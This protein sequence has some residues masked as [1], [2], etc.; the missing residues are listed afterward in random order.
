MGVRELLKLL[1]NKVKPQVLY[2]DDV[3]EDFRAKWASVS[4]PETSSPSSPSSKPRTQSPVLLVDFQAFSF[5]ILES[6]EDE[7]SSWDFHTVST[8]ARNFVE[9][10]RHHGV[11][12]ILVD[13]GA[14]GSSGK[15]EMEAKLEEW[16]KRADERVRDVRKLKEYLE[17]TGIERPKKL[18][19]GGLFT[20]ALRHGLQDAEL[21]LSEGEADPILAAELMSPRTIGILGNDTDFVLMKHGKFIHLDHLEETR[22]LPKTLPTQKCQLKL[23][24]W[25]RQQL[26]MTLEVSEQVLPMAAALCGNDHSRRLIEQCRSRGLKGK[27][28]DVLSDQFEDLAKL[29]QKALD[30]GKQ[31]EEAALDLLASTLYDFVEYGWATKVILAVQCFYAPQRETYVPETDP[32]MEKVR[33]DVRSGKLPK[34]CWPLAAHGIYF[35]QRVLDDPGLGSCATGMLM[36]LKTPAFS[37]LAPLSSGAKTSAI[38]KVQVRILGSA[39]ETKSFEDT[40]KLWNNEG[41]VYMYLKKT[42]EER[43]QWLHR[44]ISGDSVAYHK[45]EFGDKDKAMTVRELHLFSLRFTLRFAKKLKLTEMEFESLMFIAYYLSTDGVEMD[46]VGMVSTPSFRCL[47]LGAW[48]Q[49]VIV[50]ILD[51]CKLLHVSPTPLAEQLFD[52]TRFLQ[53]FQYFSQNA[54]QRRPRYRGKMGLRSRDGG[55]RKSPGDA[56]LERLSSSDDYWAWREEVTSGLN[57]E[58]LRSSSSAFD[59]IEGTSNVPN[60]PIGSISVGLPIEEHK[61]TLCNALLENRV[62]CVRGETGSGKSTQ[63]PQYILELFPEARI[64]VTQP[65]RM[66]AVNLAKRVAK[67]RHEELGECVGYRIGGDSVV[68]K[69]LNFQTTGWLLRALV[70]DTSRLEKLTHVVFDEIHE[71]SADADFLSLVVR[72]LLHRCPEVKLVIMSATLQADLFSVYFQEL[73][74]AQAKVPLVEVGGKCFQVRKVFLD[75]IKDFCKEGLSSQGQSLLWRL[76]QKFQDQKMEKK[77]SQAL[78]D[79]AS[80]CTPLIID[81]L[82]F[83]AKSACTI[84]VFLPGLQEITD[85]YDECQRILHAADGAVPENDDADDAVNGENPAEAE[86]QRR[87]FTMKFKVFAMHSQIPMEDQMAVFQTPAEDVCHFVLASNVAESSLTLPNVSAVLDLGM[88]K[89]QVYDH[90]MK[91]TYL[92]LK[93]TSKASAHQRSG[94]AGRTM[95]GT[96]VRLYPRSFYETHLPDFD[97]PETAVLPLPRLY[98]QAKQLAKDLAQMA[99]N[100]DDEAVVSTACSVLTGLVDPPDLSIVEASRCELAE[101]YALEAPEETAEMTAIGRACLSLPFDLSLSR[102]VWFGIHWGCAVDGVILACSL[103]VQDPFSSPSSFTFPDL[104]DLGPRLYRSN[105]SRQHF[106]KGMK[107]Q[108]LALLELFKEFYQTFPLDPA[109]DGR[110]GWLKHAHTMVRDYDYAV[111]PR[112]LTE[113]VAQVDEVAQRLVS[114]VKKDSEAQRRLARLLA[115]LGRRTLDNLGTEFTD[116]ANYQ[117]PTPWDEGEKL[118]VHDFVESKEAKTKRIMNRKKMIGKVFEEDTDMLRALL[119]ASFSDRLLTS[120][121]KQSETRKNAKLFRAMTEMAGHERADL[122]RCILLKIPEKLP[123]EISVSHLVKLMLANPLRNFKHLGIIDEHECIQ[124]QGAGEENQE[125]SSLMPSDLDADLHVLNQLTR[126]KPLGQCQLDLKKLQLVREGN[127]TGTVVPLTVVKPVHPCQLTWE[128]HASVEE[129]QKGRQSKMRRGIPE[130]HSAIGFVC[131]LPESPP[132]SEGENQRDERAIFAEQLSQMEQVWYGCCSQVQYTQGIICF[133]SGLTVLHPKHLKFFLLTVDPISSNLALRL[134]DGLSLEGLRLHGKEIAMNVSRKEMTFIDRFRANLRASMVDGSSLCE[135]DM[136][137]E[138]RE[139][140]D[141]SLNEGSPDGAKFKSGWMAVREKSDKPSLAGMQPLMQRSPDAKMDVLTQTLKMMNRKKKRTSTKAVW[142]LLCTEHLWK[143]DEEANM[144]NM[145]NK[146]PDVFVQKD[147]QWRLA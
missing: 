42:P 91:M 112:R 101:G 99:E 19:R 107:S 144:V 35:A 108:P 38:S 97:R 121:R 61:E 40:V 140:C 50:A 132:V 126:G 3:V 77:N 16:Q 145:L 88:N 109:R 141:V 128:V 59:G 127:E 71:R 89:Q 119:T 134:S 47:C 22:W 73:Q 104:S 133:V 28:G 27:D 136:L 5:W 48:Y 142:K 37:I 123:Q 12:V 75:D 55:E 34:W 66:A 110:K 54:L 130:G 69:R 11:E 26:A 146:H 49:D 83:L 45:W 1:K 23:P 32:K 13:D 135:S 43:L 64:A 41:D 30:A 137:N 6:F 115:G 33:Q 65:R 8:L 18:I 81:L 46:A 15:E 106:D 9:Q 100:E 105:W 80:T 87:N 96:V 29:L 39:S 74:V 62:V 93:W 117:G 58:D 147:K 118:T 84:L 86:G 143:E 20:M 122:R 36:H 68:G 67:E 10:L 113:L 2:L 85:I 72:L 92:A 103:A 79:F 138:L 111:I 124:I 131:A 114:I 21:L 17:K 25:T 53:I 125:A 76:N 139:F 116:D 94:R 129:D 52:G 44:K 90:R 63:V 120:S 82:A 7:I 78:M 57:V 95:E 102:L 31:P 14:R 56:E 98:L 24:L 60:G 70:S 4:G 51:L